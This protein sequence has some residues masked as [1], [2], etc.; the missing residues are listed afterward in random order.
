MARAKIK[1]LGVIKNRLN[2]SQTKVLYIFLFYQNELLLSDLDIFKVKH[3]KTKLAKL[4][5]NA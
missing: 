2:L 5:K 4:K 3:S 1:S